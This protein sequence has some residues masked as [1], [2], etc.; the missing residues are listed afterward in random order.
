MSTLNDFATLTGWIVIGMFAY[1]LACGGLY[2][3]WMA[4]VRII[5]TG[6]IEK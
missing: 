6:R 5:R 4:I 3:T 1:G 2:L